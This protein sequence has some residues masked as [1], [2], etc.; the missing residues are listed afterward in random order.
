MNSLLS[1]EL[2]TGHI[3]P[4]WSV[5]DVMLLLLLPSVHATFKSERKL[6]T[7]FCSL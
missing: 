2:V 6:Q 3:S 7:S 5:N 4:F 1:I